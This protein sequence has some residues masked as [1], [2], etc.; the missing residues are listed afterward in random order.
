VF[1]GIKSLWLRQKLMG[2]LA[3]PGLLGKWSLEWYMGRMVF[4]I[5]ALEFNFNIVCYIN[6]RFTLL[7]LT[8]L[9][10]SGDYVAG[11]VRTG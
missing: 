6:L 4:A 1:F 10:N 5:S 7:L 9:K 11:S 8:L 3:L 2:K